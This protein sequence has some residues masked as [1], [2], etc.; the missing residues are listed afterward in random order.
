MCTS[1]TAAAAEGSVVSVNA[2]LEENMSVLNDDQRKMATT[3]LELNQVSA[4]DLSGFKASKCI[5]FFQP[6]LR[7]W[8]A[9]APG[10]L[11]VP[12]ISR[13]IN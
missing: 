4:S 3:L 9:A 10:R 13:S 1:S 6:Y 11:M 5:Q 2:A 8:P 12:W 7:P